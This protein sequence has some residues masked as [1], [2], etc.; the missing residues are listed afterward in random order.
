G[1]DKLYSSCGTMCPWTCTNLYDDD[2]CPE[3]CNRGCFCPR[4]MVVDRNG[5]CVLATRC[6]CKYEGKMFLVS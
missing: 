5:K 3:E 1:T 6:G 2:E 4:G